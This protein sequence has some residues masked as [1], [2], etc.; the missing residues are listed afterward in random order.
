MSSSRRQD[1]K[2]PSSAE[3]GVNHQRRGV[4]NQSE[5]AE[6]CNRAGI[7]I[8]DPSL[9]IGS[10][11]TYRD[12]PA[13]TIVIHFLESDFPEIWKI[14]MG[15]ILKLEPQWILVNRH[16]VFRAR[17]FSEN[18]VDSLIDLMVESYPKISREGDDQY[19]VG[20]GG[21]ILISYDHHM[22]DN[23]LALYTND[24]QVTSLILARLN[25]LGAEIELFSKNG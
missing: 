21:K 12:D 11:L 13:H 22:F 17:Q 4:L 2:L 24:V 9:G 15:G 23:G 14:T 25:E 19:L 18:E 6:I 1:A 3:L 7:V 16:G 5:F 20:K 8:A 10:E